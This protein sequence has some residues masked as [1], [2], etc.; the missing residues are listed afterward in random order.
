VTYDP[1]APMVD[2]I[3][4]HQNAGPGLPLQHLDNY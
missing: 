4:A 3:P 1:Y 2:G